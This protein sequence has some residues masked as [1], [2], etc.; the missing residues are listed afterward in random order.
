MSSLHVATVVQQA[1]YASSNINSDTGSSKPLAVK[2]QVSVYFLGQYL[3]KEEQ[4]Q[5]HVKGTLTYASLITLVCG[6]I[7]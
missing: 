7:S 3:V 6:K 2:N 4:I 5:G 1:S